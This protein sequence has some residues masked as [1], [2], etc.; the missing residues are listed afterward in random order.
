MTGPAAFDVLVALSR[1]DALDGMPALDPASTVYIGD[2]TAA[3]S[4]DHATGQ[5]SGHCHRCRRCHS[6]LGRPA[7]ITGLHRSYRRTI[8]MLVAATAA[9]RES[10]RRGASAV[11]SP[12]SAIRCCGR[13]STHNSHRDVASAFVSTAAASCMRVSRVSDGAWNPVYNV[14][15]LPLPDGGYEAVLPAGVNAFTFFWTEAPWTP[16]HPGHWERESSGVRVFRA[17]EP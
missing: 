7:P 13:S 8:D 9:L 16:G 10:G 14:P 11:T 6:R 5:P 2:S 3:G 17:R 1:S 4:F 12:R 15:L